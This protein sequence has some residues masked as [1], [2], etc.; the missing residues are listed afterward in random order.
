METIDNARKNYNNAVMAYIDAFSKKHDLFFEGWVAD[1]VGGIATFGD[2]L[3]FNFL[4]IA[5]DINTEQPTGLI[6]KWLDDSLR[7]PSKK[8]N[9]TSYSK[10]LRF[11]SLM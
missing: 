3:F 6:I 7:F 5:W 2:V 1:T 11:E 9:Y 4:D 8:I 10:G